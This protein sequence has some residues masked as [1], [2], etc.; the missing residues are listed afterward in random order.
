M[1]TNS[2]QTRQS[3]DE[4]ARAAE[5]SQGQMMRRNDSLWFR[6]SEFFSNPFSVMRRM[7][8]DM[9]RMFAGVLNRPSRS[10]GGWT[11]DSGYSSWMPAVEV[12]EKDNEVCVCAELPG[13]RPED[14][15]IEAT[16]DESIIQG[17]RKQERK[18]ENGGRLISERQ[19]GSFYRVV[20][21]PEGAQSQQ[22]HAEFKNGELRVN[23]PV[24]REQSTRRRIPISSSG[25]QSQ[26]QQ[27]QQAA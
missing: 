16:G 10:E 11:Q 23:I 5:R 1:A 8:E 25:D 9:D 26:P 20:P 24:T 3:G 12:S 27:K 21:L 2:I 6:P 14:V 18:E 4:S 22:A 17:E 13:L 7:Q 19:Y 15:T